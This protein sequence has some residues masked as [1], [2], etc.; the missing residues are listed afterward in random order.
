[1]RSGVIIICF[2]YRMGIV[3]IFCFYYHNVYFVVQ[4][5]GI[6]RKLVAPCNVQGISNWNF[7][8]GIVSFYSTN[9]FLFS[10]V[11]LLLTSYAPNCFENTSKDEVNS[12]HVNIINNIQDVD[13]VSSV[14]YVF[15]VC[16]VKFIILELLWL[17]CCCVLA[18]LLSSLYRYEVSIDVSR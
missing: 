14:E 12:Q 13:K 11:L 10:T 17:F 2:I 9:Q 7:Y 18:S 6:H 8:I 3:P 5:P 4:A 1:M 16:H 15:L